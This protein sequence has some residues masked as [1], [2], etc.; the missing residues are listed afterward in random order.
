MM[1][2]TIPAAP[3]VKHIVTVTFNQYIGMIGAKNMVFNKRCFLSGPVKHLPRPEC[4][5][6]DLSIRSLSIMSQ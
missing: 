6:I 5:F 4:Q 3:V 2:K 1:S